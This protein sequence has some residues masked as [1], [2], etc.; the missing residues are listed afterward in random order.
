VARA[1]IVRVVLTFTVI[2]IAFANVAA[3]VIDLAEDSRFGL[4]VLG[5]G[6]RRQ[7]EPKRHEH[8]ETTPQRSDFGR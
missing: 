6:H 4:K 3:I 1:A 5:V 8:G 2:E 7:H